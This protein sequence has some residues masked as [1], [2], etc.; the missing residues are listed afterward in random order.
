MLPLAI[1]CALVADL[2]WTG[3]AAVFGPEHAALMPSPIGQL[4]V[5]GAGTIAHEI[6]AVATRAWSALRRWQQRR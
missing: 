6:G 3:V 1:R 4:A 2:A 5:V